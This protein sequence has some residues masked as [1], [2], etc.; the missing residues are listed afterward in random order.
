MLL[1]FPDVGHAPGR[2]TAAAV[3]PTEISHPLPVDGQDPWGDT[4]RLWSGDV[5]ESV[6]VLE[7]TVAGMFGPGIERIEYITRTAYDLLAPPVVDTLYA[8]DEAL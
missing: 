3:E 6:A 5:E 4:F 8:I 1:E 2:V 7:S